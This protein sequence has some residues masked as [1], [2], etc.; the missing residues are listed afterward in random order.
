M[1]M[2]GG[3]GVSDFLSGIA[4]RL[5]SSFSGPQKVKVGFLSNAKYP[6]GT[7]VAYI[8]ALNEYGTSRIPSR[9]FFRGMISAKSPEWGPTLGR[10]LKA[11]NYNAELSLSLMGEYVKGQLQKS[12]RDLKTPVNAPSTV[13]KKGFDDPLIDTGHMINSVDYEVMK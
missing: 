11:N 13:Q 6:D 9:P 10:I 7:P 2:T 8:A 5:K 12:I 4:N 1:A 3:K